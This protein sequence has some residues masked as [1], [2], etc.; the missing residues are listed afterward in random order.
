MT[1][2]N[3]CKHRYGR[4]RQIREKRKLMDKKTGREKVEKAE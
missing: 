4:H 1:G 3:T 2:S